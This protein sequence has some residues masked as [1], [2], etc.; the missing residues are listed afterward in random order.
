MKNNPIYNPV[1]VERKGQ[2]ERDESILKRTKDTG[3]PFAVIVTD[4]KSD[5]ARQVLPGG[6]IVD[7][8]VDGQ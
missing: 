3:L 4:P 8:E 2:R 7:L 5:E 1:Y 6:D